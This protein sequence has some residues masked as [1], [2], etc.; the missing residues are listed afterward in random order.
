MLQAGRSRVRILMMSLDF[1]IDLTLP[2][3]LWPWDRLSQ[4]YSWGVKGGRRVRLTASPPSV[5]RSSRKCGSLDVSQPYGP[6]RFVTGRVLSY[7]SAVTLNFIYC[8]PSI[9]QCLKLREGHI[10]VFNKP[11]PLFFEWCALFAIQASFN[12]AS[13]LILFL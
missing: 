7:L 2:A 4:E 5:D 13:V 11:L 1:S 8:S 12:F 6:S 9:G 3:A 10:I